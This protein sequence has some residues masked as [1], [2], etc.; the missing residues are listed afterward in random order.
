MPRRAS[1]CCLRLTSSCTGAEAAHTHSGSHSSSCCPT[2]STSSPQAQAL[3]GRDSG[4]ATEPAVAA[5]NAIAAPRPCSEEISQRRLNEIRGVD[6]HARID[7]A[8]Y[9]DFE[10]QEARQVGTQTC[11]A[12]L[13]T[14]TA[15][16]VSSAQDLCAAHDCSVQ[17]TL[18]GRPHPTRLLP[19]LQP[20][21]LIFLP[22]R[23]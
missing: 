1:T 14:H 6:N 18:E 11:T 4:T 8:L 7:E 19:S 13:N 20:H 15:Q 10:T 3:T 17:P 16:P 21:L 12:Q 22:S 23:R 9:L 5:T 2:S